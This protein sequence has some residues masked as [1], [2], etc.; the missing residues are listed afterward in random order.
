MGLLPGAVR[1]GWTH[2]P[3]WTRWPGFPA[4]CGGSA[5]FYVLNAVFTGSLR[6]GPL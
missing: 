6:G 1:H 3:W 5:R 2:R 4:G